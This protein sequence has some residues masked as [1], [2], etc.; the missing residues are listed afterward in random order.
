ML[1]RTSFLSAVLIAASAASADESTAHFE[2]KVRPVLV[3]H[4]YECHSAESGKSK[5]G[6]RL[7]TREASA[8]A[9]T[10][11]PQWS[12]VIPRRVS[13]SARSNTPILI[14]R[15]HRTNHG[16][17]LRSSRTWRPGSKAVPLILEPLQHKVRSSDRLSISTPDGNSGATASQSCPQIRRRASMASFVPSSLSISCSLHPRRS[18]SPCCDGSTLTSSACRQRP[19]KWPPSPSTPICVKPRWTNCSKPALRRTL[20]SALAGRGALRRIERP[21]VEPDFPSRMALPR[22]CDRRGECGRAVRPLHHRAA[23]GRLTSRERRVRT[24]AAA[25]CHRL[26]RHRCQRAQRA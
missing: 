7:D 3:K 1:A 16:C 5:G 23:R 14:W 4:C 12:L 11:D 17:Q 10:L 18:G 6:L 19:R 20:G 2:S 8:P 22:L 9:A 15:C 24:R 21:R 25:D 26:S 13:C